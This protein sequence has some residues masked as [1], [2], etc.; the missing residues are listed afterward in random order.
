MTCDDAIQ[1]R[2]LGKGPWCSEM[3]GMA[4]LRTLPNTTQI[5][6]LP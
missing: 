1:P 2:F 6:E 4:K 3:A 5:E